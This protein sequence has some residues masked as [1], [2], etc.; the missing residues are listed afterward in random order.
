MLVFTGGIGE[1]DP[2]VRA[3]A[4]T[5]PGLLGVAIDEDSSSAA[6]ALSVKLS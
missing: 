2:A 5:G 6:H 1:P 3:A 4:A